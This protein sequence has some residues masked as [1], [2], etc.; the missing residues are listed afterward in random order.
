VD[1]FGSSSWTDDKEAR[2]VAVPIGEPCGRC[3]ELIGATDSGVVMPVLG[4]SELLKMAF[5]REC[6]L[7]GVFGSV[8]HQ[9]HRC[10][11]YG[12]DEEDPP[13]MT[14]REAAFA[15]CKLFLGGK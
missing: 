8:G 3:R 12:G 4:D 5:H 15:A 2:V 1:F 11:C 10:S 7:R 9:R 14:V 13:E 6:F